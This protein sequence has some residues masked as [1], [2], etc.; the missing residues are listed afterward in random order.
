MDKAGSKHPVIFIS[1]LNG[2]RVHDPFLEHSGIAPGIKA[3]KNCNDDNDK[4]NCNGHELRLCMK[5][6]TYLIKYP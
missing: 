1:S 3:G 6:Y 4:C 2:I 5:R